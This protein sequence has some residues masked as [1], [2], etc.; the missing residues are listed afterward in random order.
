MISLTG[1]VAKSRKAET[2][3][4]RALFDREV[5]GPGRIQWLTEDVCVDNQPLRFI[6][7]GFDD[8]SLAE[9]DI[10]DQLKTLRHDHWVAAGRRN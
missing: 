8:V 6:Q 1:S 9:S 2:Y 3:V 7:D 5:E 10:R 4:R